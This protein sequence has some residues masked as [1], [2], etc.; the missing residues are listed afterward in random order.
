[1]SFDLDYFGADE[2]D[3]TADD[4]R[5][6]RVVLKSGS[7]GDAVVYV[8][9]L[10]GVVADGD[11]GTKTVA[12]VKAFQSAHGL[13]ADGEVGKQTMAALDQLAGKAPASSA[14]VASRLPTNGTQRDR[15]ATAVNEA[16]TK[17]T[18]PIVYGGIALGAA[19]A[20]SGGIWAFTR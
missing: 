14:P 4:V 2:A 17:K 9:A 16:E 8:Q 1:M 6:G 18:S 15:G 19:L 7:K 12:A 11:Y 13:T 10:V 20:V 5:A 3:P